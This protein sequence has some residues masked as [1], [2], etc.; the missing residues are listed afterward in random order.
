MTAALDKLHHSSLG[1]NTWAHK[2]AEH[3]AGASVVVLFLL[4]CQCVWASSD[5][6]SNS[7]AY[8]AFLAAIPKHFS[9]LFCFFSPETKRYFRSVNIWH[10]NDNPFHISSSDNSQTSSFHFPLKSSLHTYFQLFNWF[11]VRISRVVFQISLQ[12]VINS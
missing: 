3:T 12:S 8:L 10:W 1:G 6:P 7:L 9:Q 5:S 4:F 11:Q 2:S